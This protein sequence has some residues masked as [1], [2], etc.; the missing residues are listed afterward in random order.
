MVH[1]E[2]WAI[3]G[4]PPD[5]SW[6]EVEADTFY[7]GCCSI[8]ERHRTVAMDRLLRRNVSSNLRII[9]VTAANERAVV[10]D[11]AGVG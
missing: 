2:T 5:R 7:L 1:R 4:L 11:S 10:L 9:C 8:G 6:E 3:G